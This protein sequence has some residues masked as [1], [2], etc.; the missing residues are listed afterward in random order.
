M[1]DPGRIL[2]RLRNVRQTHPHHFLAACPAHEDDTPS[3]SVTFT[4][5]RVLLHCFAGCPAEVVL[6]ALGLEWRDLFA[7]PGEALAGDAV[8]GPGGDETDAGPDDGSSRPNIG[9]NRGERGS[10]PAPAKVK[11]ARP[12]A[13]KTPPL[14]V[15]ALAAAKGLP[16][17]FLLEWGLHERH[18][19]VVIPYLDTR[20]HRVAERIRTHPAAAAGSRW[21]RGHTP[22]LYGL[23]RLTGDD[24]L[25]LVEGESDTWTLA[26]HQLPVLGIPGATQTDKLTA[27]ALAGVRTLYVI[28]EPDR[29]GWT[30]V[31]GL[32]RR[33]RA[34]AWPGR[35]FVLRMER[36]G[37]KDPNE[38]HLRDRRGFRHALR[39][40]MDDAEQLVLQEEDE[41]ADES[42]V[43]D[44][45]E[46]RDGLY[47]LKSVKDGV[48]KVKLCNFGARITADVHH[49]DGVE[50]ARVFQIQSHLKG[51][52]VAF[53]LPARQFESLGWVHDKM[54]AEAV[55]FPG[56]AQRDHVRVAIQL[57]SRHIRRRTIF[58]H[59]GWRQLDGEW[60]YLH[61]GGAIGPDGDLP[62]LDVELPRGLGGFALP[63][64]PHRLALAEAVR[65]SLQLLE[66]APD[67][68]S[69]PLYAAV[70]RAVLGSADFGLHL[71]GPSGSGKTEVAAL[72][73]QHFGAG[74]DARRLPG[75]WSSTG[76]ALEV[77]A[78]SLKDALCVVDD[79]APHG[80]AADVWR[81]HRE[82]ER[83]F[84]AQGNLAGR[85]RLGRDGQ[86]QAERPPR[87]LIVSTGEDVPHGHSIRARLLIL[88]L[89]PDALDWDQL[90]RCQHLA[91]DGRFAAA[92]AGFVQWLAPRYAATVRQARAETFRYR[93]ALSR[94]TR[95]RRT[96]SNLA[97]L[98]VACRLFLAFGQERQG[99]TEVEAKALWERMW[100]ALAA[101]ARA[102]IGQQAAADP[103]QCFL[104]LLLAALTSGQAHLAARDGGL[105]ESPA[106]WGWREI[107]YTTESRQT[108]WSPLGR[109][110]GWL[111]AEGI[112]LN[113][114]AA[115]QTAAGMAGAGQEAIHVTP[116]TLWRRLQERG[117]L[118]CSEAERRTLKIRRVV[119][120]RV[121]TVLMLQRCALETAADKADNEWLNPI[122]INMIP[123]SAWPSEADNVPTN[124]ESKPTITCIRTG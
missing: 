58:T 76:N 28:Q 92:L 20:G 112:Y 71:T 65:H 99:L 14:T 18:G 29:G 63:P 30:F 16:M 59:T 116:T 98:L 7:T 124:P 61:G 46:A 104:D 74:L 35:A 123:L 77:L 94:V 84:R 2:N 8:S 88:E 60:V 86:L 55:L 105:P 95:H 68:V 19:A 62:D 47:L 83:L 93:E 102:Q 121:R 96:P 5:E 100:T 43:G 49:D 40:A 21:V 53:S 33:L 91:A 6:Q 72:A 117:L 110:I 119:E 9:R 113:A 67:A 108:E 97:E 87:G 70:W 48:E 25:F 106:A 115:Y 101:V 32:T 23:H 82:A 109:R 50:S 81:Y 103:V 38:L 122:E 44:Y 64:L 118:V 11:I 79:F 69:L 120:G 36:L 42:T 31:T 80:G 90:T 78:F 51:R 10:H 56:R 41:D 85:M 27:E 24:T 17:E 12:A 66:V 26:L 54:G 22:T 1:M 15:A 57:L 37:V 52:T 114:E 73:Q 34:L 13:D 89:A 4:P 45:Q 107:R 75:G 39:R 111:D 3:L